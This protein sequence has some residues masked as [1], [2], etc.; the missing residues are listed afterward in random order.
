MELVGISGLGEILEGS[1]SEE[2]PDFE[3]ALAKSCGIEVSF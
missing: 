1:L 3:V 2:S